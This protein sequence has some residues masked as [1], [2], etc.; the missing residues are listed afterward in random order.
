MK[1]TNLFQFIRPTTCTPI[2]L[3]DISPPLHVSAADS[4]HQEA[5]PTLKTQ[6]TVNSD[7]MCNVMTPDIRIT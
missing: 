4:H 2:H 3:H 1:F 6:N 5:T 7:T